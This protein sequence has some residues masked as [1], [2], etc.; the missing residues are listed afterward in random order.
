MF[1]YKM[2]NKW[3]FTPWVVYALPEGGMVKRN[4][5]IRSAKK[6]KKKIVVLAMF[7]FLLTTRV[8]PSPAAGAGFVMD[9]NT[10]TFL[11]TQSTPTTPP[12]NASEVAVRK[13]GE[14]DRLTVM[15]E[16]GK[17]FRYYR[18]I[19]V[20]AGG[21]N[22]SVSQGGTSGSGS[23]PAVTVGMDLDG[24][25]WPTPYILEL[26]GNFGFSPSS[27]ETAI[28]TYVGI[29]IWKGWFDKSQ[30]Y[31]MSTV[32]RDVENGVPWGT[33][34]LKNKDRIP[35]WAG[36]YYPVKLELGI[37]YMGTS[38]EQDGGTVIDGGAPTRT[39]TTGMIAG[40][41]YAARIGYFGEYD[42]V[43]MTGYYLPSKNAKNGGKFPD[44]F[45]G[46]I[47]GT[48]MDLDAEVKGNML[49]GKLDWYHRTDERIKKGSI[50]SGYGV[51][52]IGRKIHLEEGQITTARN[53]TGTP[54][55][56]IFP[57]QDVTQ[58]E[59]LVTVGWMR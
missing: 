46:S 23:V 50:I 49:E 3:I 17:Y 10:G 2:Y 58:V 20:G 54:V 27:G 4:L 45:L 1:M 25:T 6:M 26:R 59:L 24:L 33:A 16:Y 11:S 12:K 40:L 41:A 18:Y 29:P 8:V 43:R 35:Q 5:P 7:A 42:M 31:K 36:Q 34:V 14:K 22:N 55:L 39:K 47:S 9:P 38:F 56:T 28:F 51:S 44:P 57:A 13:Q 15:T 32:E 37:G 19:F 48:D 53:F 52:L 30:N 21:Q